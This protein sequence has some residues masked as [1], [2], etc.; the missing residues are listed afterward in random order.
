MSGSSDRDSVILFALA[1]AKRGALHSNE[2]K[3]RRSVGDHR[4][5]D[6]RRSLRHRGIGVEPH[7]EHDG[8]TGSDRNC[9]RSD[10]CGI[11]CSRVA[12]ELPRID[13]LRLSAV[14]VD[15]H[16]LRSPALKL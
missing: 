16:L 2:F 15:A 3:T 10:E 5:Y 7:G 9:A 14:I 4:T 8:A 13:R 6:K 12:Y 11:E 1:F